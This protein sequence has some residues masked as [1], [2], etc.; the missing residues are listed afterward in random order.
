MVNCRLMRRPGSQ[1]AGPQAGRRRVL[2]G[3]HRHL[4]ARAQQRDVGAAAV[5]LA[6]EQGPGNISL[7]AVAARAGLSKGGLLYN[8]P[9]KAK[10][11]DPN[12][13]GATA[14]QLFKDGR[15]G[16]I[17]TGPWN[18]APFQDAGVNFTMSAFP[19]AAQDGSPFVGVQGF[20]INSFSPD[21]VL[22]QSFL[23][24]YIG[25]KEVQEA[26]YKAGSRPPAYL[27]AR[28][29]MDDI[30]AYILSLQD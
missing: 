18:V 30:A 29:A 5:A 13:D 3:A 8:F 21:K 2:E 11:L 19:T 6:R 25:T 16:C 28:E 7:D 1:A 27:P 9:T 12:V 24:D 20:M 10:L 14:E 15:A 4:T 22:A 26:I 23:L 17:I